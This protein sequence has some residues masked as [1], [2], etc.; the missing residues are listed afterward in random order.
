MSAWSESYAPEPVLGGASGELVSVRITVE[1]RELEGL[2]EALAGVSFPINP[3]LHHQAVIVGMTA[4]GRRES[5]AATLVEFPAYRNDLAEVRA[6]LKAAGFAPGSVS[7][8]KMLDDIQTNGRADVP[9][10]VWQ[11]AVPERV[12]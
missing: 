9:W 6:V 7:V 5:R 4:A 1:P 8:R 12:N 10:L 3:Q 11:D 2:L